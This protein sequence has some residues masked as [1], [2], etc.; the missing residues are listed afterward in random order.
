[1]AS[2][3]Y[4]LY[5]IASVWSFQG[6]N[7]N[8]D[9]ELTKVVVH[10][11]CWPLTCNAKWTA[12]PFTVGLNNADLTV[13]LAGS[14]AGPFGHTTGGM[15]FNVYSQQYGLLAS[16]KVAD[17]SPE[18]TP[19][20]IT[21]L[22]G[23]KLSA[24]DQITFEIKAYDLSCCGCA[25]WIEPVSFTVSGEVPP[26]QSTVNVVVNVT[27][28]SNGMP[29]KGATVKLIVNSYGYYGTATTDQYG[30]ATFNNVPFN[31]AASYQVI[32]TASGYES[33]AN[34][35]TGSELEQDQFSLN[36]ALTPA[37]EPAWLR[38]LKSAA[39]W[40]GVIAAVGATAYGLY[41]AYR[42][43]Y[44]HRAY[45]GARAAYQRAAPV[46]ASAARTAYRGARGLYQRVAGQE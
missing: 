31:E 13:T 36:V 40:I 17:L 30:N 3:T 14:Y 35:Y 15:E 42:R 34:T 20:D 18:P 2:Q 24:N 5:P 25:P 1:M 27:D 37:P 10:P 39:I 29:I 46:V 28:A 26:A 45:R 4:K 33:S 43:G 9:T 21:Q 38:D 19:I 44:L 23:V 16:I 8:V 12:G 22:A 41:V 11:P 32:V 7:C 6:A